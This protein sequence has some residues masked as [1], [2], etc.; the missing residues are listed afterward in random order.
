MLEWQR[1]RNQSEELC[2]ILYCRHVELDREKSD[3]GPVKKRLIEWDIENQGH[4]LC[5]IL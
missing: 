5:K 1:E 2:N 4:E 3:V